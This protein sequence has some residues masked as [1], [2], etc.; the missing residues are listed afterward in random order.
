MLI[1]GERVWP[2][3][4]RYRGDVYCGERTGRGSFYDAKTMEMY[5]GDWCNNVRAGE[6]T[7]V[8]ADGSRYTGTARYTV[9]SNRTA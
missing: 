4:S 2:D 1:Q 5:D 9:F 6:G 3:G 8:W 7:L